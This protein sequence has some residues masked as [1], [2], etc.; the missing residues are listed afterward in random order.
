[1]VIV[2][3][4]YGFSPD[5]LIFCA[6]LA[7]QPFF[8]SLVR[9]NASAKEGVHLKIY[10]MSF[11]GLIP[12][13]WYVNLVSGLGPSIPIYMS[14]RVRELYVHSAVRPPSL[15]ART[16]F[17]IFGRPAS[18]YFFHI[19]RPNLEFLPFRCYLLIVHRLPSVGQ[20]VIEF[21]RCSFAPRI[22]SEF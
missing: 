4:S 13:N 1:M 20:N 21:S 19:C 9:T 17:R 16:I 11:S 15:F 14:I 6:F 22:E 8:H 18:F 7:S 10:S 5:I 3:G 12:K 2:E